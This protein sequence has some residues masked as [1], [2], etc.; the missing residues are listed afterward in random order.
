MCKT[1]GSLYPPY[2][3]FILACRW[4]GYQPITDS[5]KCFFETRRRIAPHPTGSGWQLYLLRRRRRLHSPHLANLANQGLNTKDLACCEHAIKSQSCT[6]TQMLRGHLR[7][8]K[9]KVAASSIRWCW[10]GIV[11]TN[12]TT[13]IRACD[14]NVTMSKSLGSLCLVG[15]WTCSHSQLYDI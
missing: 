1:R 13:Y 7:V 12:W 2:R 10:R 8:G 9:H 3:V 5:R 14:G 6:S 11:M 15:I 4:R